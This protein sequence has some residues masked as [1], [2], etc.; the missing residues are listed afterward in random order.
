MDR[1]AHSEV[2]G[3]SRAIA[4]PALELRALR[5][6]FAGLP[7]GRA[8]VL[9]LSMGRYRGARQAQGRMGGFTVTTVWV[10]FP[11]PIPGGWQAIGSDGRT[12]CIPSTVDPV[13]YV[14]RLN[15]AG[16]RWPYASE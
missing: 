3:D 8:P 4:C 1:Y 11:F 6:G 15:S 10:L 9:F 13:A 14:Q 16:D 5:L 2:C 12:V 7:A